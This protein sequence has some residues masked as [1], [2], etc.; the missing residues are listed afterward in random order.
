MDV[1]LRE[2]G[3]VRLCF[4][5]DE[6]SEEEAT[7][8][9][10]VAILLADHNRIDCVRGLGAVFVNL[11]ELRLSHNQLGRLSTPYY[12]VRPACVR[13][14]RVASWIRCLPATLQVLDVS[15]NSLRSFLECDGAS[16]PSSP[17]RR[18]AASVD[19]EGESGDAGAAP[20][21]PAGALHHCCPL[22]LPLFFSASLF[23][24][25]RELNLSHNALDLSLRESD[26][27]QDAF[28]AHQ[29]TA[30]ASYT[31]ATTLALVDVSY[32]PG[33][34]ALNGLFLSTP[35][36]T[37]AP[38]AVVAARSCTLTM[39]GTGIADLQGLSSIDAHGAGVQWDLELH[40]CPVSRMVLSSA[41][42]AL[43]HVM[44][45][46]VDACVD[47]EGGVLAAALTEGS[48]TATSAMSRFTTVDQV[49]ELEQIA[50]AAVAR[51]EPDMRAALRDGA[52]WVST[53]A[54]ACLL[55]QVVPSLRTLDGG[56]SAERC[57][58]LLLTSLC[59]LLRGGERLGR[60][61]SSRLAPM[62]AVPPLHPG[63]SPPSAAPV[64]RG[65]GSAAHCVAPELRSRVVVGAELPRPVG[66]GAD[67][68]HN[69][70]GDGATVRPRQFQAALAALRPS[71]S[72]SAAAPATATCSSSCGSAASTSSL[73]ADDAAAVAGEEWFTPAGLS[74]KDAALYESLCR[75]A[76]ELQ[77]AVLAGNERVRDVRAHAAALHRQLTQDRTL[78]ADQL[79][80]IGRL[81]VEREQLTT[82]MAQARRRLEKRHK[83]VTYGVAALQARE[84]AARERA[85]M[86]RIA[87]R[88]KEVARRERQL[89]RRAAQS[90]ALAV[91][92]HSSGPSGQRKK[93]RSEV[94]R[95][96]A[97]R[98]RQAEQENKDPL[99]YSPA[100]FKKEMRRRSRSGSPRTS[101]SEPPP[102]RTAVEEEQ[103]YLELYDH[104]G[105]PG[106]RDVADE[107]VAHLPTAQQE[108]LREASSRLASPRSRV[109]SSLQRR[110]SSPGG[111][112]S[113]SGSGSGG[114]RHADYAAVS[115]SPTSVTPPSP[116]APRDLSTLSLSELLDA[117]AAIRQKQLALQQLQQ[118]WQ[119]PLLPPPPLVSSP[120]GAEATTH[121]AIDTA[122]Q[123]PRLDAVVSR[124]A[125]RT[126]SPFSSPSH[127]DESA[128]S[129]AQE[130]FDRMLEQRAAS[131][132]QDTAVPATETAA[133]RGRAA[134]A[135]AVVSAAHVGED[136]HVS[137]AGALR[138]PRTDRALFV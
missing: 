125:G 28:A 5:A 37:E 73:A 74:S 60:S 19:E 59:E 27:M 67:D 78:V 38:V 89:R 136:A 71:R 81:R 9:S 43:L 14:A 129:T 80:E 102:P 126:R 137:D 20:P 85:A 111:S 83:D 113:G 48:E 72:S 93:L 69:S 123:T 122:A 116:V 115:A 51:E 65:L 97:V 138:R 86:E 25:L 99:A 135:G 106:L 21:S 103:A 15:Y 39:V 7:V 79:R 54:Y 118:Q 41:P 110:G 66:V 98:K 94:L 68:D 100:P 96:A 46:I 55:R 17:D 4:D 12:K 76:K 114:D 2:R 88:E 132:E 36:P 70:N 77:E 133:S 92:F 108:Q 18:G 90:G 134:G 23:P 26:E 6:T 131:A 130:L 56:L 8:A 58:R 11:V 24:Q 29:A 22:G 117:A 42:P 49:A 121:T 57:E 112:G 105:A 95:E 101:P 10:A 35:P 31:L 82:D 63:P 30:A 3:I 50:A 61:G 1:D 33:L 104:I 45:A 53:L 127:G 32:N 40:P 75:E 124:R 84:V 120:G 107:Y 87:A 109:A 91:E 34:A 47:G 119:H 128:P 13:G 16:T 62:A 52:S 44:H 64:L